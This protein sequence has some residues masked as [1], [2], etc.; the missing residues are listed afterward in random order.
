LLARRF[1]ALVLLACAPAAVAPG[2][3]VAEGWPTKTVRIVVPFSPG[4][5]TDLLPRTVF[6]QVSAKTGH[7]VVIDN[8]PGGGGGIG[9]SAVAKAD[10]DGHTLLVH[11]N[12]LV[13]SPAIQAMPYDPVQDFSGITPLGSVPLV[14]IV[15]PEKG[16]KTLRQLVDFAKANPDKFNYGAAG[17]GTPPHLTMERFRL[18]AGFKG[19]VVPFRGAPE[20]VTEILAGRLD[21][22]FCPLPPALQFIREGKLLALAVSSPRRAEALPAVPTTIES[23]FPDSDFEFYISLVAPKKTPRDLI[24]RIH[25][26]TVAALSDAG[27]KEKLA[28]LGAEPLIMTPEAYDARIAREAPLA[29]ELAKAAGI[30][31]K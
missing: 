27:V 16:I 14:L 2:I 18:V 9:V 8:R 23:G 21:T 22:Y 26:E 25:Q 3:A 15:S 10:P 30:G 28:K 5:A 20:A 17:I 6:E 4:S 31:V 24:A 13:T 7:P 12:A 29:I 11:S 1:L 19:Q